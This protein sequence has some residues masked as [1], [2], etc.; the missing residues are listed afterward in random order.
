M[1]LLCTYQVNGVFQ[2]KEFP[3]IVRNSA[4]FDS[5]EFRTEEAPRADADDIAE[6]NRRVDAYHAEQA[7]HRATERERWR[8][9]STQPLLNDQNPPAVAS[10]PTGLEPLPNSKWGHR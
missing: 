1:P 4:R 5:A 7:R 9:L 8:K 10:R 2:T 3:D 6:H